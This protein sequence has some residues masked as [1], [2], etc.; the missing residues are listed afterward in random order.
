MTSRNDAEQSGCGAS[1]P[2]M[3]TQKPLALVR[4]PC[5][6]I[7]RFGISSWIASSC[8]CE[9]KSAFVIT[10]ELSSRRV[11]RPPQRWRSSTLSATSQM[12]WVERDIARGPGVLNVVL[13]AAV[14][15]RVGVLAMALLG[16][17]TPPDIT[18]KL[19]AY[20]IQKSII[21]SVVDN[22][23]QDDQKGFHDELAHVKRDDLLAAVEIA[24][25]AGVPTR[26]RRGNVLPTIW[27]KQ[28][29][30]MERE[31]G[32]LL[33]ANDMRKL[34]LEH[35][36]ESIEKRQPLLMELD[37]T[38]P[39]VEWICE[40]TQEWEKTYCKK[41]QEKYDISSTIYACM[42]EVVF[43]VMPYLLSLRSHTCGKALHAVRARLRKL[44]EGL[45]AADKKHLL[46][47]E[48]RA[49]VRVLFRHPAAR[50]VLVRLAGKLLQR[51]E[52]CNKPGSYSA[53]TQRN[54]IVQE[55][56]DAVNAFCASAEAQPTLLQSLYEDATNINNSKFDLYYVD[57]STVQQP[58]TVPWSA[59]A[60]Q[61][62]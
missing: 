30:D 62:D 53:R 25:L 51:K 47:H 34:L 61:N 14:F 60:P 52:V 20:S 21:Q 58:L 1:H 40:T 26:D 45:T 23:S 9:T 16:A 3:T 8:C 50:E 38:R 55:Y 56:N 17:T 12:R 27:T 7:V 36:R 44:T 10:T 31:T 33:E 5:M 43:E 48:D 11:R 15:M 46:F 18:E 28:V 49:L 54:D 39:L 13:W 59:R 2:A 6:V 22:A 35:L 4:H 42:Q 57:H 19:A 29:Q 32:V 37:S 24:G 41:L